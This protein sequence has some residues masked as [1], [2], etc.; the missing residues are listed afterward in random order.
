MPEAEHTTQAVKIYAVAVGNEYEDSLFD[1]DDLANL[2]RFCDGGKD[3]RRETGW[4]GYR[5]SLMRNYVLAGATFRSV[6]DDGHGNC[7]R[8]ARRLQKGT[9]AVDQKGTPPL[10]G[11][12]N[13]ELIALNGELVATDRR[14]HEE[15]SL[16]SRT[17]KP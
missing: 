1:P 13:E 2:V 3:A 8:C 15:V 16:F 14:L 7:F 9:V 11:A 6:M 12:Q 4:F 10:G 5:S 17:L